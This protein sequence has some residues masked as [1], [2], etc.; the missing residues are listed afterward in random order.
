MMPMMAMPG[1]PGPDAVWGDAP[2]YADGG[3]APG[4]AGPPLRV[5]QE[6]PESWIW[7][8]DLTTK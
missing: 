6:F 7:P 2:Y 1:V 3:G 8:A 5:R 4:E